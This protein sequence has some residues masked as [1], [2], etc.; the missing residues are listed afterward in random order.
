MQKNLKESIPKYDKY[1]TCL[2]HCGINE[3]SSGE[4]NN[5]MLMAL[6]V[7]FIFALSEAKGMDNKMKEQKIIAQM[8]Y[9]WRIFRI[10][11][12]ILH[13]MIKYRVKYTSPS[14]CYISKIIS[15][16][17]VDLLELQQRYEECTG[18]TVRYYR[19]Y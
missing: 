3:I 12:K 15:N 17:F 8:E 1:E 19:K 9:K 5:K 14:V 11:R 7:L 13:W 10:L 2:S 4:L 18:N 6:S 16:Y